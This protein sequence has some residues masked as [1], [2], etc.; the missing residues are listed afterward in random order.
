MPY[1]TSAAPGPHTVVEQPE[2]WIDAERERQVDVRMYA[3]QPDQTS[4]HLP[5]VVLSHGLGESRDSYGYLARLW[6]SYGYVVCAMT[7]EG[8]DSV[9]LEGLRAGD[10]SNLARDHFTLRFG[11]LAFVIDRLLAADQ[12]RV[13]PDRIGVAGHSMGSDTAYQAVGMTINLPGGADRHIFRD[14]RVKACVGMGSHVGSAVDPPETA[15]ST[16]TKRAITAQ[17]WDN[18]TEPT[19]VIW[20]T[21]DR[22]FD[23]PLLSNPDARKVIYDSIPATHK[24]MVD[25]V[26]LEHHAFTDTPPWYPGSERDPR[27]HGWIT[28]ITLGFLD[29][30]V[31][32]NG[33]AMAWLESDAVVKV[34]EGEVAYDYTP[35]RG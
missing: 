29:A 8:S 25:I 20:G 1:Q 16:P 13:D 22:E 18:I 12:P 26:D 17:A 4:R 21:K 11:D 15:Q 35:R 14:S 27:H 19:M 30:H 33:E 10:R 2:S 3:P 31:R 32:G 34:C 6:A 7:H 5:A 24:Y 28:Q 23:E 9:A